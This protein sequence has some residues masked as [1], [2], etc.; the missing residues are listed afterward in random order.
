MAGHLN[1]VAACVKGEQLR[2]WTLWFILD[3]SDLCPLCPTRWTVRIARIKADLSNY[4]TLCKLLDE[5]CECSR[6]EYSVKAGAFL[7][8]LEHFMG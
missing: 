2:S 3:T 8:Q 7:I 1:G 5:I 6:D 4:S